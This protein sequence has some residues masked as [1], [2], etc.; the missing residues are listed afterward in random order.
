MNK[1]GFYKFPLQNVINLMG[2]FLSS[3]GLFSVQSVCS[4]SRI[5]RYAPFLTD[6]LPSKIASPYDKA[7]L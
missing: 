3:C 7:N 2:C 1:G 6:K 4:F 5:A